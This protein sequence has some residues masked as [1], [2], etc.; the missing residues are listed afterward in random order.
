MMN[1]NKSRMRAYRPRWVAANIRKSIGVNPIMILS[2]A[3]QTG[4]STLLKHEKP[5]TDWRYLSFDDLDV[6]GRAK[7]DS[8]SLLSIEVDTVIDEIQ[9][10]PG[11]LPLIKRLVDENRRRRFVLSGSADLLLM[12][13]VTESLAGRSLYFSL[14]PCA[15]SEWMR[16]EKPQW[17]FELIN[18]KLPK[19][20][21]YST[22]K[23]RLNLFRGFLPPVL[24]LRK[25]EHISLW[26]EGYTKTYLERDLRELSE[27]SSLSDFKRIMELLALRSGSILNETDIARKCS[28]SQPTV[29]RYINLLETS[30]LFVKLRPFTKSKLRRITKS[31]KGYFLEPG[32]A[33]YLAGHRAPDSLSSE[34]M[35]H[36]FETMIFLHLNIIASLVR[37]NLFYWRTWGGKEKEIDFVFEVG[38]KA[39]VIEVKLSS[40]VDYDDTKEIGFFMDNY[41]R[42]MA[43]LIIYTGSR[44]KYLTKKIIAVPWTALC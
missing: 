20:D 41:P 22:E 35:G 10:A 3:R 23:L 24:K 7:E 16:R 36:L 43:G 13:K 1:R 37:A 34:F 18:G 32:L 27:V 31:P 38:R 21:S 40:R 28:M 2:G 4:K 25:I 8:K 9:K 11:I 26:W 19:E 30:N 42:T 6:L 39:I 14:L 15:L 12:H 29:H 33:C 5:F 44:M 17:F